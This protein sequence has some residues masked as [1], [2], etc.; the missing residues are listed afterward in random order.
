MPTADEPRDDAARRWRSARA[1]LDEALDRPESERGAYVAAAAG[2]DESLRAEVDSLLR[3]DVERVTLLGASPAALADA[4]LGGVRRATDVVLAPGSRLGRFEVVRLAG[5]GGMATVYLGRDAT[6][7]DDVALKVLVRPS[8]ASAEAVRRFAREVRIAGGL[9]HPHL[10]PALDAGDDDAHL[11]YAMPYV[12]GETLR[13]RLERERVLTLA[14][15][16]RIVREI[17]SALGHAHSRGVVHRDVKPENILLALD[18]RAMLADFGIARAL[19][20]EGEAP[21]TAVGTSLGT[22]AYMSPEQALAMGDVD[23]RTDLYA[24]GCVAFEML[25]GE[26]PHRAPSRHATMHRRLREPAPS[27]RALRGEVSA[28]ADEALRRAHA[29][30]PGERWERVGELAEALASAL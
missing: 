22:A 16:A 2:G 10:I 11:W 5:R 8:G 18:G 30:A 23:A 14:Q 29:R 13:A 12:A 20:P 15:T 17:A 6:T 1:I 21:L 7:G 25:A 28:A 4:M 26:P 9:A 19:M 27:V 3:A 24:L